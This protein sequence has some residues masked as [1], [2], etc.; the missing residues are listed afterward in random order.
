MNTHNEGTWCERLAE[1]I[2]DGRFLEDPGFWRPHVEACTVC[3][4]SVEGLFALRERL[5]DA[6]L[7]TSAAGPTGEDAGGPVGVAYARFRSDV[8]RRGVI[9]G[10]GALLLVGGGFVAWERGKTAPQ[11]GP[12]SRLEAHAGSW[13]QAAGESDP[14]YAVR[15]WQ[16]V[17]HAQAGGRSDLARL[18]RDD[19]MRAAYLAALEHGSTDV[20]REAVAALTAS[21]IPL[22]PGYLETYLQAYEQ[23]LVGTVDVAGAGP[24]ATAHVAA[25][26]QAFQDAKVESVLRALAYRADT[27]PGPQAPA[28][29]ILPYL[30]ASAEGVR[31]AALEVLEADPDYVAGPE[32]QRALGEAPEPL[33]RQAAAR[34]LTRRGGTAGIEALARHYR[35]ARR[36][37]EEGDSAVVQALVQHPEGRA[38]A[39][40]RL[41]DP[42]VPTEVA[43]RYAIYL[44]DVARP[45]E[46]PAALVER[47]LAEP[48]PAAVYYMALAARKAD[49]RALRPGLQAVWR[50]HALA[51]V[52]QHATIVR[53]LRGALLAWDEAVGGEDALTLALEVCESPA[54]EVQAGSRVAFLRRAV[55]SAWPSIRERAQRLLDQ[56]PP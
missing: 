29:L 4:S 26:R 2:T 25:R 44:A 22:G 38:L 14:A 10:L 30:N 40:E 50:A 13:S 39:A 20:R 21:R 32:I 46:A 12:A 7:E 5:D 53:S 34:V 8:R 36:F 56:L 6:A 28:H 47:T 33:V 54:V 15:L 41:A 31:L 42:Q 17:F 43:W 37:D 35:T 9:L 51:W 11:P 23:N 19:A 24:E 55:T 16:G 18:G 27:G 3:R 45:L 52:A 49:W 1:A 48:Q